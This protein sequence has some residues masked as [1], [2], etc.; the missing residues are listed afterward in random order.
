MLLDASHPSGFS[1]ADHIPTDA[2][3]ARPPPQAKRT[4]NT[5]LVGLQACRPPSAPS[6]TCLL[7]APAARRCPEI[8]RA[9]PLSLLPSKPSRCRGRTNPSDAILRKQKM[10][11]MMHTFMVLASLVGAQA[12]Q[13]HPDQPLAPKQAAFLLRD[14]GRRHTP[15]SAPPLPLAAEPSASGC[16]SYHCSRCCAVPGGAL[17]PPGQPPSQPDVPRARARAGAR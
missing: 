13:P 5:L 3:L 2:P 12:Y 8:S 16:R 10:P 7:R 15:P 9:G 6:R 17:P 11:K 1:Q 4:A 14:P